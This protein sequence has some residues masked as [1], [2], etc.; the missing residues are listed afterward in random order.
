MS[1]GIGNYSLA[2]TENGEPAFRPRSDS[3]AIRDTQAF[4]DQLNKMKDSRGPINPLGDFLQR[5]SQT[6]Q[7]QRGRDTESEQKPTLRNS[8]D[9]FRSSEPTSEPKRSKGIVLLPGPKFTI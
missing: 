8:S 2:Q 3:S 7:S 5:N 9:D 4:R 6:V 1:F